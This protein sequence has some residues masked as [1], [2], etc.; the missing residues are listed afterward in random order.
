MGE[1]DGRS[2]RIMFLEFHQRVQ[3]IVNKERRVCFM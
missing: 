2:L 3:K 1:R